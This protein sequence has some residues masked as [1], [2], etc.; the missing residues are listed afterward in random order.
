MTMKDPKIKWPN[1]DD[2]NKILND[3][4][5]TKDQIEDRIAQAI[6]QAEKMSKAGLDYIQPILD[7]PKRKRENCWN[8]DFVLV[9]WFGKVS[10]PGHVKD[11]F[12]R[13]EKVYK[14]CSDKTLTVK[15]KAMLPHEYIAQNNGSFLSPKTFK[16]TSAW[17]SGDINIRGSV[18]IHEL[19]HE[20]F[21]DQKI[22]GVSVYSMYLTKQLARTNPKSARKSPENYE[23]F[24]LY[25]HDNSDRLLNKVAVA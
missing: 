1:S 14:R 5:F 24:C 13:L 16:V 6:S 17:I 19:M 9:D 15:I 11:V 20:W 10:K 18:I 2:T 8:N 12:R 22:E 7:E 23:R 25:I 4:N 21:S 3:T